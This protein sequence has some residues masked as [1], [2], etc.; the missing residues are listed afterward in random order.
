MVR[1]AIHMWNTGDEKSAL[2]IMACYKMLPAYVVFDVLQGRIKF[3]ITDKEEVLI[4]VDDGKELSAREKKVNALEKANVWDEYTEFPRHDW[5]YEVEN[6][7][8]NL[9]YWDWVRNKIEALEE[10]G[11]DAQR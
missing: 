3:E 1:N 7:D 8:T 4:S 6:D 9:G 2:A 10:E 5:A 11:D